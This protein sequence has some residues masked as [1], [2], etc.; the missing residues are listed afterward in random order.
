[1][2]CIK[3]NV[4]IREQ[5]NIS[6]VKLEHTFRLIHF[7]CY[8]SRYKSF[9]VIQKG[10]GLYFLNTVSFVHTHKHIH[11]YHRS[12]HI[13]ICPLHIMSDPIFLSTPWGRSSRRWVPLG[14]LGYWLQF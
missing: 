10:I 12:I 9:P 2:I 3:I 7:S 6:V 8:C 4:N 5:A 13:W 14:A 1:M 11:I